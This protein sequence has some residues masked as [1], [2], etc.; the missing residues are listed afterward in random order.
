MLGATVA[1]GVL[2]AGC[3][4]EDGGGGNGIP[5]AGTNV[6]DVPVGFLGSAGARTLLGRDAAGLY[7][8]TS[9]CTHNGCDL[10]TFGALGD[11][12]LSCNCHGSG[13]SRTGEAIRGPAFKPLQHL[14]VGVA[15][16]GTITVDTNTPV[17]ATVR[18]PVP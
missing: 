15:A 16:D 1:S 10:L 9:I 5:V 18:T 4:S 8:M 2:H 11:S 13:F 6:R 12:G 17:D 3:S 14:R 7:A